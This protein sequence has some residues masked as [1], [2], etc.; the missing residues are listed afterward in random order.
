MLDAAMDNKEKV[1]NDVNTSSLSYIDE[2][3]SNLELLNKKIALLEEKNRILECSK[4]TNDSFQTP[5][6]HLSIH[7]YNRNNNN[8]NL[9]LSINKSIITNQPKKYINVV[10]FKCISPFKTNNNININDT[11]KKTIK[12]KK[13]YTFKQS[14]ITNFLQK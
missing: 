13:K 5:S 11:V 3:Q 6:K 7:N 1:E 4:R 10:D 12:A 8:N 14:L 2:I 9:M